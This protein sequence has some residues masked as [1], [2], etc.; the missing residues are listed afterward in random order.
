[1]NRIIVWFRR[2]LR[3]SDNTALANAVRDADDI[4]P[5]FIFDEA[6]L[7]RDD[8][9]A[10]RIG[11]MLE[12]LVALSNAVQR[13]GGTFVFRTGNPLDELQKLAAESHARA[14]YFNDDYEPY[15]KRRDDAVTK[16]FTQ[17]GL[18]IKRF[19]DHVLFSGGEIR[20][21]QGTVY[22]VFTPYKKTWFSQAHLIPP[23]LPSPSHLNTPRLASLQ[24]PTATEL[25]YTPITPS[26]FQKGGES[27]AKRLLDQ[28]IGEKLF[29]YAEQ[30]DYPTASGTSG[31]SPHVKFGTVSVR[32]IFHAAQAAAREAKTDAARRGVAIFTSELIWRD[33][34]YQ[35]L[36][37]FP[38]VATG[39]F[40]PTYNRLKWRAN[41]THFKAWCDGQ[42]GY[43]IVDAAMRQLNTTGWMHNR[44]RMI[45][46][47]FLTK[48]LLISWQW[49]EKYFMQRL[50]DGDLAANNGGWQ[51]AASTG[52]DAQPYFRIFNPATQSEKF[53]PNGTFIKTFVPELRNVPEKF[54]HTP[55]VLS[56]LEQA[57]AGM[58]HYAKPIVSHATQR[59]KA[60]AMFKAVK[61]K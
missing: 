24:I 50:I 4:V 45:A 26:P 23:P 38:H 55:H 19:K 20:T 32:T 36:D 58:E 1:M 53:D 56:P 40:K 11:F 41:E 15:S 47:S 8:I 9:A 6:I 21:K 34:Y 30:R 46:A 35:I 2:D 10:V 12:S 60:L 44:L 61:M 3:L 39:S 52:T 27:N 18:A 28:L 13:L 17:N 14:I 59:E 5:V 51:W 48:D 31:L 16:A 42:T 43:P 29:R 37:N 7:S 25:G 54:I 57:A 22:T 49:G 33:F